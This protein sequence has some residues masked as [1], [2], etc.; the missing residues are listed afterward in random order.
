MLG[1]TRLILPDSRHMPGRAHPGALTTLVL[2]LPAAAILGAIVVWPVARVLVTSVFDHGTYVGLRHF[3]AALE[4][5]G[6]WAAIGRTLLWGALVPAIVTTAGFGLAWQ[7]R[8]GPTGRIA[9]LVLVAPIALPLV[10]TGIVFRLV[11]DPDPTRG[12]ATGLTGVSFLSP[13]LVTI[14]LMSAFVWAWVGLALLVFRTALDRVQPELADVVRKLGGSGRDVFRD[15]LWHPVMRRT[16]AMVFAVVALATMRSFDLILVMAPGSV[17]DEASVLGVLQWQTSAG[18]LNG[19]AAALGVIWLAIVGAAIAGAAWWTRQRWPPPL[20]LA[21]ATPTPRDHEPAGP[22][23][24]RTMRRTI[25]LSASALWLIPMVV[26]VGTSLQ[27]PRSAALFG[28]WHRPTTL[29]SYRRALDSGELTRSLVL[30]GVLAVVVAC[31][32]TGLAL[33]AA[34]ATAWM[35]SP[36][37]HVG[38]FALLGAAV[39]PVLVIA[40]PVDEVLRALHLANT[41]AG[42]ALVHIALGL[43]FGILLLRNAFADVDFQEIVEARLV[44]DRPWQVV[45]R[46]APNVVTTA[47]AVLVLEFIQVWDDFVVGLLFGGPDAMPLGALLH[48]GTRQFVANSGPLAASAVVASLVPLLAVLAARRHIVNGLV[49]GALR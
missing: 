7:T 19:P 16:F 4:Q 30:T 13:R 3:H 49:S 42:L 27:S 37:A 31:V 41:S 24:L 45:Q 1:V 35:D 17:L 21:E 26:L 23:A 46:L 6:A 12:P 32:V 40:G 44:S 47:V 33:L 39:V 18:S 43:P 20:T 15:A 11:Y 5:P 10:V 14:A 22:L 28:W 9:T 8:R 48:G 38:G 2:A 29:D 25:L 36:A 34:Y